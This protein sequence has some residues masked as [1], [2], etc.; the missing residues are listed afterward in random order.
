MTRHSPYYG[1]KLSRLAPSSILS[2]Y[3]SPCWIRSLAEGGSTAPILLNGSA[4]SGTVPK[5]HWSSTVF[6]NFIMPIRRIR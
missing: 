5:P 3:H 6:F 2:A 4:H 1:D